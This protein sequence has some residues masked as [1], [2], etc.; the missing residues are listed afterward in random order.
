MR[1]VSSGIAQGIPGTPY[2]HMGGLISPW[3][4]SPAGAHTVAKER[5][6][7][8]SQ[9]ER[10]PCCS[11]HTS[12]MR[13]RLDCCPA[14]NPSMGLRLA[15]KSDPYTGS[16]SSQEIVRKPSGKNP[17]SVPA[18]PSLAP[19]ESVKLGRP[20]QPSLPPPPGDPPAIILRSMETTRL[21][22]M[23]P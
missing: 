4:T 15:A 19:S 9:V 3:W 5:S 1:I 22:K 16:R 7:T 8:L 20:W 12:R 2:T 17:E 10:L 14:Q 23:P 21:L 18:P 6:W 13:D 11:A